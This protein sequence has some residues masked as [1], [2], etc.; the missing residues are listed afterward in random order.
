MGMGILNSCNNFNI[1]FLNFFSL[2]LK[3]NQICTPFGEAVNSNGV[4]KISWHCTLV[5]S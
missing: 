5:C 4:D 1:V 3:S 2:K